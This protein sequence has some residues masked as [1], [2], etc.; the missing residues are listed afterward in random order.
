MYLNK[1][2]LTLLYNGSLQKGKQT[3]AFAQTISSKINKQDIAS[4][5]VS[6]SLFN[7]MLD[8]FNID[9]KQL[10]NRADPYYQNELRNRKFKTSEWF[11]II[12]NRPD[13]LV[14]P[15]GMFQGKGIVCMT[16]TDILKIS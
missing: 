7:L 4:V 15:V 13:L 16:P 11:F 10:I 1:N 9:I 2:E 14:H 3:L 5:Q 12:K 8:K 6:Q